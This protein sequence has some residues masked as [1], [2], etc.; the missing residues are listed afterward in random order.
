MHFHF[1]NCLLFFG[2]LPYITFGYEKIRV[3]SDNYDVNTIKRDNFTNIMTITSPT[4]I[5][6]EY[7]GY[8]S[9]YSSRLVDLFEMIEFTLV[10][11]DKNHGRYPA[12]VPYMDGIHIRIRYPTK[13]VSFDDSLCGVFEKYLPCIR[14]EQCDSVYH[15][16][17]VSEAESVFTV[18]WEE[19]VWTPTYYI[20]SD[21]FVRR[22]IR[23]FFSVVIFVVVII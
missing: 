3:F 19:A 9:E 13:R 12:N 4:S 20:P 16:N 7:S 2:I 21:R 15:P 6:L 22:K 14:I 17:H 10:N 1:L 5:G 8:S 11:P 18:N 23:T